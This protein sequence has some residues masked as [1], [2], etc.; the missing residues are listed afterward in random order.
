MNNLNEAKRN[1]KTVIDRFE[2]ALEQLLA[3][4][5]N[6]TA[7]DVSKKITELQSKNIEFQK[8]LTEKEDEITY[9]RE[10]NME[11][12]AK[13]GKEQEV[14][15]QLLSKNNQAIQKVDN[16]INEFSEYVESATNPSNQKH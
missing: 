15:F 14:N 6:S 8:T 11:L 7:L 2:L 12:Q 4:G 9:L 5:Q 16:L 13:V 1:L 3:S 10:Q